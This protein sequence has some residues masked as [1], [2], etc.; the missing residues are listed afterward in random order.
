MQEARRTQL[1]LLVPEDLGFFDF[2]D[3][4]A[5][6]LKAALKAVKFNSHSPNPPKVLKILT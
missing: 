3:I 4:Y 6:I 1:A 2:K 5:K